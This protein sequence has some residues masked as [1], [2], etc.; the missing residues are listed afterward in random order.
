[1]RIKPQL[2]D[3]LINSIPCKDVINKIFDMAFFKPK[4]KNELNEAIALWLK[5]EDNAFNIYG[6]I[7]FWNTSL[8]TDMSYIFQNARKFNQPIG[9]WDV[10]N[11]TNMEQMFAYAENFN[12]PIGYWNVSN[13]INMEGLFN[14]AKKFNQQINNWN[15]SQVTDMSY[16]FDNTN[17]FNQPL[18]DWKPPP[19]ETDI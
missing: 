19:W 7:S 3:S 6:H 17:Y 1:M 14:D 12:Q 11:V 5:N 16:M 4:T 8:I 10:S 2:C 9:D 13:V 15:T 18:N